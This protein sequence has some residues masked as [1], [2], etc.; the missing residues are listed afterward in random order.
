M[1][2]YFYFHRKVTDRCKLDGKQAM[3]FFIEKLFGEAPDR[4]C[5]A[6]EFDYQGEKCINSL[7]T[8]AFYGLESTIIP[9]A[10]YFTSQLTNQM[11]N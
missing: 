1:F 6:R 4:V 8:S 11:I 3:I 9:M 2:L 5:P 7:E 10:R